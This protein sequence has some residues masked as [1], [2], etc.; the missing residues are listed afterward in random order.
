MSSL[1]KFKSVLDKF[2][3]TWIFKTLHVAYECLQPIYI[4]VIGSIFVISHVLPYIKAFF[5]SAI[6]VVI[7]Y[8]NLYLWIKNTQTYKT[9][10]SGLTDLESSI[11]FVLLI[12]SFYT[13]NLRRKYVRAI[14]RRSGS[15][16]FVQTVGGAIAPYIVFDDT[17]SDDV[18]KAIQLLF[19]AIAEHF[20]QATREVCHVSLKIVDHMDSDAVYTVF[21]SSGRGQV[22]ECR[23]RW[24]AVGENPDDFASKKISISKNTAFEVLRSKK[25]EFFISN[26]LKL[27]DFFGNYHNTS[28][29]WRNHYTATIVVPIQIE[30]GTKTPLAGYVCVDSHQGHFSRHDA[31]NLQ[32]FAEIVAMV[33]GCVPVDHYEPGKRAMPVSYLDTLGGANA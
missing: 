3:S 6:S 8:E 14:A 2:K 20:M 17:S 30:R 29:D 9:Y 19:D 28:E 13:A 10:L 5:V 15:R 32:A 4:F 25:R 16:R 33:M 26:H 21:R 22:H 12:L 24:S 27:R 23:D 11:V 18:T 7:N 1:D 31:I